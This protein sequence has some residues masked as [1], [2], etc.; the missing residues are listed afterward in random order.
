MRIAFCSTMSCGKTTL[1]KA[2][3]KNENFKNYKMAVERSKY[4]RDFGIE[5]NTDSTLIGQTIFAAERTS[6]LR[7]MNIITD[8]SIIDVMA[9]TNLS[10][11]ISQPDKEAFEAFYSRFIQNYDYIFYISPEGIAIEDNGVRE[12]DPEYRRDIDIEI[13]NIITRHIDKVKGG[14]KVFGTTEERIKQ[15]LETISK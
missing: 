14:G 1:V 2:L 12:T 3:S 8:R 4:L 15:V 13:Q 5:L 6:E 9:F 10:K 11:T 7:N